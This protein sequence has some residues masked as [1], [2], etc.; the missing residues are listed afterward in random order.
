MKGS[1]WPAR[2]V[3]LLSWVNDCWRPQ[4]CYV[5]LPDRQID[6]LSFHT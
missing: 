1:L 4:N 3:R 2:P 6:D 5:S